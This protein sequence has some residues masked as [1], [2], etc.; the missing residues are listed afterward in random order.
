VL[1]GA[2]RNRS[3]A[4]RHVPNTTADRLSSRHSVSGPQLLT[5]WSLFALVAA[6]TELCVL[7]YRAFI[8][9]SF[10]LVD[11]Q[12]LWMT[13]LSYLFFLLPFAL[14]LMLAVRLAPRAPRAT[15]A[16]YPMVFVATFG[17]FFLAH[18]RI[19]IIALG[20]LAIGVAAQVSRVITRDL[21]TSVRRARR[22][23]IGL[24]LASILGT[25][26]ANGTGWIGAQGSVPTLPTTDATAPNVL[27]LILDTVRASSLSLY[28]HGRPTTPT[29][30]S[31]AE[32]AAVFERAYST[33][34]WT[35]TSH[36]GMFT[37]RY[38]FD[39]SASWTAPLD[40]RH[41][42]LAEIL[43]TNGYRTAGFVANWLY[44]GAET[45]LA[46]GFQ[47]YEDYRVSMAEIGI[48]SSLGRIVINNPR[49]RNLL[50]YHDIPGRRSARD[51]TTTFLD[52]LDGS[53]E[54]P[55]FAFLNFY[56]AHEPYL[57]PEPFASRFS[58][59]VPRQNDLIRVANIRS[60]DR[61]AKAAMS[62]AERRE[63][64]RAY[65][66]A[67]A[68]IDAE[69]GSLLTELR[70]IGVLDNTIVIVTSDH[71]ELFGEHGL[72]AHGG[73][74]YAPVI[75]VPLLFAGPGVAK[76]VRVERTI[77]LVD[78]GATVLDLVNAAARPEL[79]GTSLA[80]LWHA[81][82]TLDVVTSPAYSEVKPARN[83]PAG[84]PSARGPLKGL[85]QYPWHYILNGDGIEELYDLSTDPSESKNLANDPDRTDVLV[86]IRTDLTNVSEGGR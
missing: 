53:S 22:V 29:L 49:L 39:L 18:P 75:H 27:L 78:I 44:T 13:P 6:T 20:I 56:D 67:V 85:V 19:H 25:L 63:E 23:S 33:A 34:P 51:V 1:E 48:A 40:D 21:T 50:G 11:T 12:V 2:H 30:D 4:L 15:V 3:V 32:E 46:R 68:S 72:F 57:P 36:A 70:R 17:V 45:G 16:V 76:G 14:V 24:A 61:T 62:E 83:Q 82:G 65:E 55:F 54:R 58:S 38:P 80:P 69:I 64:E 71:G 74:L 26:V 47:H 37:G 66:A 9:R 52:W 84:L 8:G 31:L 59:G 7:A 79:P 10:V 43:S 42:T 41:P 60:A 5:L 73:E 81:G 35:L 86:R 77:S 28:G